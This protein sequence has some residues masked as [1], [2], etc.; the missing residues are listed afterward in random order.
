MAASATAASQ[1]VLFLGLPYIAVLAGKSEFGSYSA[2]LGVATVISVV[3]IG[4]LELQIVQD[5]AAKAVRRLSYSL[6][7]A[8]FVIATL[9]IILLFFARA[10]LLKYLFL[11]YVMLSLNS[12]YL[13]LGVLRLYHY[14]G[15]IRTLANIMFVL[16][17][18]MLYNFA[19]FPF[20]LHYVQFVVVFLCLLFVLLFVIRKN[21]FGLRMMSILN[22]KKI[23]H[24]IGAG[25]R[26]LVYT[27]PSSIL[28]SS[29]NNLM[30][31]VLLAL[32]GAEYAA[33]YFLV[34]KIMMF[35]VGIA[36]QTIGVYYRRESLSKLNSRKK[37]WH[38]TLVLLFVLLAVAA[39][40]L[41]LVYFLYPYFVYEYLGAEWLDTLEFYFLIALMSA[42][43][44][45]YTPITSIFLV[46]NRQKQDFLINLLRA[47][48]IFFIVGFFALNEFGFIYFVSAIS[49]VTVVLNVC[50][51]M[52]CLVLAR[53]GGR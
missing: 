35:P 43:G 23:R 45:L 39:L 20:S 16:V 21:L 42:S 4:R 51:L 38:F 32:Y 40:F 18:A 27:F 34:Y 29:I 15:G 48:V 44:V 50:T 24:F 47:L 49:G 41:V 28:N 25:K 46:L 22:I 10:D 3:G 33:S 37:L 13:Y 19:I 53:N 31:V 2:V 26:F 36:G 14:V 9:S 52:F 17:S 12:A 8:L 7:L 30:P 5:S 11:G 1:L 6:L